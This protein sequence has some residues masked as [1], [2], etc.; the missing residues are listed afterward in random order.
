LEKAAARR[1]SVYVL[2]RWRPISLWCM[3]MPSR[4]GDLVQVFAPGMAVYGAAKYYELIFE[5]ERGAA[6]ATP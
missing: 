4:A 6:D 5:R 1:S 2:G 3:N